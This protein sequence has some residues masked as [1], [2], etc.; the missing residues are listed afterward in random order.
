M[1]ALIEQELQQREVSYSLLTGETA[2]RRTPVKT[3]ERQGVAV[4]DQSEGRGL[5]LNLTAAG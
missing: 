4:S 5:G 1:L 2:D 3:S